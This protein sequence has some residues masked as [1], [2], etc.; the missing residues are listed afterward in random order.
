VWVWLHRGRAEFLERLKEV[1]AES[2]NVH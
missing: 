1:E 2:G